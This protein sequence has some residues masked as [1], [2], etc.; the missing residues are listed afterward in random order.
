MILFAISFLLHTAASQNST[1]TTDKRCGSQFDNAPCDPSLSDACCSI[2]G[3]VDQH[4]CVVSTM[5]K[6]ND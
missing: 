6:D 4:I 1:Y 5:S 2:N 3:Y